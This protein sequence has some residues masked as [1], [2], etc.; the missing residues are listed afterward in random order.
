MGFSDGIKRNAV[1]TWLGCRERLLCRS[2][3]DLW[4]ESSIAQSSD[5]PN[6]TPG[7]SPD[8]SMLSPR[9]PP[10]PNA[11][12]R[13]ALMRKLLWFLSTGLKIR[14]VWVSQSVMETLYAEN[15]LFSFDTK[16]VTLVYVYCTINNS[17]V[18]NVRTLWLISLLFFSLFRNIFQWNEEKRVFKLTNIMNF[19][20]KYWIFSEPAGVCFFVLM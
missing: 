11:F 3:L 19:K 15:R 14:F 6:G 13:Q 17:F 18:Q 10:L 2:R 1:A 12:P 20:T 9:P 8:A 7:G 16:E 4:W 5:C